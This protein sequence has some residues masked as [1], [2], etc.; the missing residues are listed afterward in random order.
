[1]PASSP[2][3]NSGAQEMNGDVPTIEDRFHGCLL[4]LAVGDGLG[5]YFEGQW[6]ESIA[7]QYRSPRELI[8]SPPGQLLYTDDTQM[9]IGIA[10][11]L[12]AHRQ[13]EEHHLCQRFATNYERRRG[14][15]RGARLILEAIIDGFDHKQLAADTFPGGSFGNGAAMRVAPVGLMFRD[16]HTLLWRQAHL[17]AL[18]TH[19]H[20]LGIEG[21]Q[22][23]ALAVALA[24]AMQNFD[25]EAYFNALQ[26]R[27]TRP[28]YAEPL[29]R[30][31]R[32]RES[33]ELAQFGNGIEAT[34]SVVTAIATFALSPNDYENTIGTA[35]L[36]G[37]DTDTIAA[38][39]GAISGA[40]LG[41]QAI[42][43]H[44]LDLLEDGHHGRS[45]LES[46]ARQLFNTYNAN[47]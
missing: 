3:K 28:E 21:A 35:I 45:Y 30:A 13:I 42:P 14:Y 9:M 43:R 44:L 36:L 16:D 34:A 19:T 11:T 46:L 1:M 12:V 7:Q 22:V 10:E 6:S 24:S 39:A 37:G 20:P 31:S 27:C 40:H 2:L 32:I 8:D 17:S 25:R 4:G 33:A 38:M 29:A 23:L 26:S 5:A 47:N 15:G 18:P 41:V